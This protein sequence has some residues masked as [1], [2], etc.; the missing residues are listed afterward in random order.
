M[1]FFVRKPWRKVGRERVPCGG[2]VLGQDVEGDWQREQGG[3]GVPMLGDCHG[4]EWVAG[5]F[6]GV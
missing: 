2:R 5:D 4:G 6:G 1:G 3:L